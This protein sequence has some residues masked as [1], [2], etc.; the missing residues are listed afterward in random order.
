MLPTMSAHRREPTMR[1]VTTWK[2]P[3][4][5][6][7]SRLTAKITPR[8]RGRER[9]ESGCGT[10]GALALLSALLLAREWSRQNPGQRE[11]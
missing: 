8:A 9:R 1:R 4:A 3:V 6:W 2:V 7:L 10:L 5:L 11:R